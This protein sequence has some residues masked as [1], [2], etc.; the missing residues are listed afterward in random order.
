MDFKEYKPTKNVVHIYGLRE[1]EDKEYRYVGQTQHLKL[2]YLRHVRYMSESNPYKNNWVKKV[3]LAGGAIHIDV[4]ETTNHDFADI[5]ETWWMAFYRGEGHRLTNLTD[6][7]G[8]A[9]GYKH[10][11]E[12]RASISEALKNREW[13]KESKELVSASLLGHSVSNETREKIA[14]NGRRKNATSKVRGVS[15]NEI[16]GNWAAQ[17]QIN[18]VRCHIG[19]FET[20][21][22]AAEACLEA[23]ELPK[24]EALKRYTPGTK[25]LS[26]NW[27]EEMRLNLSMIKRGRRDILA[28]SKATSKYIGVSH[29]SKTGSWLANINTGLERVY[30]GSFITEAGA[31]SAYNRKA[32]EV[33]GSNVEVNII[34]GGE[35]EEAPKNSSDSHL[36]SMKD[37]RSSKYPGISWNNRKQRWMAQFTY[38]GKRTIVGQFTDEEKAY[39]AYK[40]AIAKLPVRKP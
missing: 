7:G 14:T 29:Q 16:R 18:G 2:R 36:G 32:R 34:E 23:R 31:A 17:I 37:G 40:K 33:F 4:L 30:L 24:E 3:L 15:F 39:E 26:S 19:V 12:A 35:I 11:A 5:R 25:D 27:T 10:T 20:E 9:R 22:E 21:T 28:S 1:S 6:A 8:S 13:T 38:Q